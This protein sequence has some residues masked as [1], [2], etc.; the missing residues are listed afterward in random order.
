[1]KRTVIAVV[2]AFLGITLV[3]AQTKEWKLDRAHSSITF[4]VKHMVISEVTGRFDDF[5][6]TL[7]SSKEDFTDAAVEG[8]I[9]VD[10]IDSGNPNRDR[11][12]KTDDFFNAQ[13]YPEIKFK[14]SSVVK[15]SDNNYKIN[16]DLTIR[17]VTKQVAW[18]AVLNGTLKTS[19]GTRVAWKA[20]LA[21]NR[22]D[23]GVKWDR[24]TETG[25]LVAGDIVTITILGEFVNASG[26]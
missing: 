16:G 1:M 12:L 18:D 2:I 24:L 22:F 15:V 13:K 23:Y 10:S 4:T 8:T 26:T 20:T 6:M 11:H 17:D 7:T 25:G 9:K 14:S 5:A 19:R 21:I 3:F